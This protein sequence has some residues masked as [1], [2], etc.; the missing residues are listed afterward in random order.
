MRWQA[1][2]HAAP[3]LTKAMADE[4]FN[5]FLAHS[6]PA[7]RKSFRAGA[8]AP[9]GLIA[10]SEKRSVRHTWDHAFPPE[11]KARTLEMVQ[12]IERA[13]PRGH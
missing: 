11:S 3:Y 13:M 2:H 9:I 4:N 1:I 10:I 5:F 7:R 6:G 12:A 8:A